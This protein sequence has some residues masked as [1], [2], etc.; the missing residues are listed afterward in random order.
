MKNDI[1]QRVNQTDVQKMGEHGNRIM[2]AASA[3]NLLWSRHL[4]KFQVIRENI[5]DHVKLVSYIHTSFHVLKRILHE[6]YLI[7]S[8][9]MRHVIHYVCKNH[10]WNANRC[11]TCIVFPQWFTTGGMCTSWR[12]E[13]VKAGYMKDT[14]NDVKKCDFTSCTYNLQNGWLEY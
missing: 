14:G 1:T 4:N 11:A 8:R 3:L 7:A 12:Y 9:C 13:T 2:A 5:R 10:K 6:R